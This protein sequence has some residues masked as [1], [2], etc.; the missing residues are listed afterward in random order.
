MV[1]FIA[2]NGSCQ[3]ILFADVLY[4]T[5]TEIKENWF[6]KGRTQVSRRAGVRG[7]V[8]AGIVLIVIRL[9]SVRRLHVLEAADTLSYGIWRWCW[10][11]GSL[12]FLNLYTL[13]CLTFGMY[14]EFKNHFLYTVK[15]KIIWPTHNIK[16]VYTG[17]KP[18]L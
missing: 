17:D 1:M 4:W 11:S 6:P 14:I 2:S 9:P 12:F 10:N 3:L 8:N 5:C 16:D 13:V 7:C 15:F 18:T